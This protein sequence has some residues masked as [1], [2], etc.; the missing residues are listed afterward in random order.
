MF[1]LLFRRLT[2]SLPPVTL[3]GDPAFMA[4]D[5]GAASFDTAA[6]GLAGGDDELVAFFIN[7]AAYYESGVAFTVARRA[8]REIE[9]AARSASSAALVPFAAVRCNS[10]DTE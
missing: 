1:D 3:A 8:I 7:E 10:V 6:H 2:S 4:L 9:V 5:G